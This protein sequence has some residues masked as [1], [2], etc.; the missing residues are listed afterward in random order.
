[1]RTKKRI[2]IAD[3]DH[4]LI[5][6]LAVLFEDRGYEATIAWGGRE[7]LEL[8]Q[9]RQFDVILLRE[10]FPD[11]RQSEIW[12]TI[13]LLHRNSTVVLLQ[14]FQP[15]REMSEKLADIGEYCTV[16]AKSA[17]L[18]FE[19]VHECLSTGIEHHIQR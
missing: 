5:T 2:L 16:S 9:Y 10:H 15:G 11:V 19:S 8:L 13:R 12:R 3:T 6:R 18:I 4:D 7:T 17:Y 14:D 1:M